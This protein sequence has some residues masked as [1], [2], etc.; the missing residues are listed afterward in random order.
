MPWVHTGSAVVIAAQQLNPTIFTQNWLIERGIL[1]RDELMEGSL[2]SDFVV[3]VRSRTFQMLVLPEQLQFVPS[4]PLQEQQQFLLEKVG[5]IV[6]L[7]PQT[8]FKAVGLNFAW[9]LIPTDGDIAR[10]SR[11]LFFV[12]DRPISRF[13]DAPDSHFGAYFSKSVPPFRMKLDIKPT[14]VTLQDRQERRM[15][16]S[17]NFH[18]DL[19]QRAVQQ[20]TDALGCWNEVVQQTE[21]VVDAVEN[22]NP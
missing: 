13:F 4:V 10:L 7:L 8:P 14:I 11:E 19:D 2:F 17:F 3:Q 1:G 6:N 5:A 16:F 18:A 22:R 21:R 12:P 9:H 15:L 20:I